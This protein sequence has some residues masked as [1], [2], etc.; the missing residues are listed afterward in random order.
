MGNTKM[1][2]IMEIIPSS[3][4]VKIVQ[5]IC[6]K[7]LVVKRQ[8][9]PISFFFPCFHSKSIPQIHPSF[10][11]KAVKAF[12]TYR[13][14]LHPIKPFGKK[15]TQSL[16]STIRQLICHTN[17]TSSLC[18]NNKNQTCFGNSSTTTVGP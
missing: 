4:T 9:I 6:K 5:S 8:S 7:T 11:N 12:Q 10:G 14:Q 17:I 1:I 16:L 13:A 15:K 3:S 2:T 18:S